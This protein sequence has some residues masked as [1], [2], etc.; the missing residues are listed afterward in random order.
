MRCAKSAKPGELG[1]GELLGCWGDPRV[2]NLPHIPHS[3][4]PKG[5]VRIAP[6]TQHSDLQCGPPLDISFSF[7]SE[8][9]MGRGMEDWGLLLWQQLPTPPCCLL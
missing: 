9:G 8:F 3:R 1:A 5:Q 4:C 2:L 7:S 6:C